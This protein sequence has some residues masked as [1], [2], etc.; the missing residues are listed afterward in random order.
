MSGEPAQAFRT[1]TQRLSWAIVVLGM[2]SQLSAQNSIPTYNV[3]L[4][5]W[6]LYAVEIAKVSVVYGF[7][8][9]SFFSIILDI[10]FCAL[11]VP[12]I[13]SPMFSFGVAVVVICLFAK[14]FCVYSAAQLFVLIRQDATVVGRDDRKPMDRFME[15]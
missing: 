11:N 8:L 1:S 13:E 3:V 15:S 12:S 6:G 10:V 5:F 9:F 7:I 14:L 4:G 2:L